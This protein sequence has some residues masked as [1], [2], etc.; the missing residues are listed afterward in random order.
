ME[1]EQS[2]LFKISIGIGFRVEDTGQIFLTQPEIPEHLGQTPQ[3]LAFTR[4]LLSQK[5][6]KDGLPA[7]VL[8]GPTTCDG[9]DPGSPS[10]PL[11]DRC[12]ECEMPSKIE[13]RHDSCD[14]ALV[15]GNSPNSDEL[16][17]R[18]KAICFLC[19]TKTNALGLFVK[20]SN[21]NMSP[22]QLPF[23]NRVRFFYG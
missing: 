14:D 15:D 8:F 20:R 21:P 9:R 16:E 22:N 2:S 4:A 18:L 12:E 11:A 5:Y 7:E 19:Q 17:C 6:G 13:N 1:A 10:I 3:Y 23:L